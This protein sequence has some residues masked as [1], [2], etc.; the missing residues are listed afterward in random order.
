ML[1]LGQECGEGLENLDGDGLHGIAGDERVLGPLE[2]LKAVLADGAGECLKTGQDLG[3]T[4]T[5]A[6][7]DVFVDVDSE[8]QVGDRATEEDEG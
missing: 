3:R 8:A 6:L 7:Q 2:R 4:R 1:D 5:G